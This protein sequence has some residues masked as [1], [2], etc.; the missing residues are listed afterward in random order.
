MTPDPHSRQGGYASSLFTSP[1]C[2]STFFFW[3][4]GIPGRKVWVKYEKFPIFSP[5]YTLCL[6]KHLQTGNDLR[7]FG[8]SSLV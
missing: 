1:N 3:G 8:F 2:M 5:L 6:S 7:K 4:T